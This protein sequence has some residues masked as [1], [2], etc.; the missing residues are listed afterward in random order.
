MIQGKLIEFVALSSE[1]EEFMMELLNNQEISY[2]EGKVEPLISIDRQ[3]KWFADNINTKNQ[4]LIIK[5]I[6]NHTL[7]GYISFK[8]TNEVSRDGHI[9]IKLAKNAQGKGIGTD[10]LKLAMKYFFLKFNIH[11]LH[12]HIV[13]YNIASQKLFINKC[14]W[15]V[16]GRSVKSLYINGKYYDNLQVAILQEEFIVNEKDSFYNPFA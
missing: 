14:G 10:S 9:A 15:R 13:E 2:F 12:S 3:R 11:R 8:M 16:E 4:Y 1:Y 7:L 5:S 6:E